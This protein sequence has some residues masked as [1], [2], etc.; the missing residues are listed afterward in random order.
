MEAS[1]LSRAVP[2]LQGDLGPSTIFR[3][4]LA[5]WTAAACLQP[6]DSYRSMA[7]AQ[8]VRSP[9]PTGIRQPL[10]SKA[11]TSLTMF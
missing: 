3:E 4:R 6:G 1:G 9:P 10:A 7:A 8:E 2:W 5:H 11:N